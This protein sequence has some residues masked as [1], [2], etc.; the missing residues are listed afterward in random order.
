MAVAA[1]GKECDIAQRGLTILLIATVAIPLPWNVASWGLTLFPFTL[2]LLPLL[3][4][5]FLRRM[6]GAGRAGHGGQG[7]D[8]VLVALL[9]FTAAAAVSAL[10][11][12][13][14]L[15]H[16]F[17]WLYL[18]GLF[19]FARYRLPRLLGL[20][21]VIRVVCMVLLVVAAVCLV[22]FVTSSSFGVLYKYF[23]DPNEKLGQV[24][25][26][27]GGTLKRVQGPF[28]GSNILAQ[29][30][31]YSLVWLVA[32]S[33]ARRSPLVFVTIGAVVTTILLT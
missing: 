17:L 22:Q 18:A 1:A 30:M 12:G 7:V 13:A 4:G 9:F 16:A 14:S 32:T 24:Y 15:R 31:T 23:P 25:P 19:A 21:T 8:R 33:R 26:T 2:V 3:F 5:W 29:F 28:F 27:G 20:D 11:N 6:L 10:V